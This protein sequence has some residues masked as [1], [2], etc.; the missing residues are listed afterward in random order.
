MRK[1]FIKVLK[2]ACK[3]KDKIS[4]Y[5]ATL[6][7][8]GYV[9]K[10]ILEKFKCETCFILLNECDEA[11]SDFIK[12]KS[13][14]SLRIPTELIHTQLLHLW[15]KYLIYIEYGMSCNQKMHIKK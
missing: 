1:L 13:S 8:A 6:Y 7:I 3:K 4:L 9:E 10:R 2:R 5:H 14:H 12:R 15:R 11:H